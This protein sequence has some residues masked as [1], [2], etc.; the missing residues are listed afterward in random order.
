MLPHASI[1]LRATMERKQ[2][3]CGRR[4]LASFLPVSRSKPASGGSVE[5]IPTIG[6]PTRFRSGGCS[7][8]EP[9]CLMERGWTALIA[10]PRRHSGGALNEAS[11]LEEAGRQGRLPVALDPDRK[12]YCAAAGGSFEF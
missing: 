3:S 12:R 6:M 7:G 10:L 4:R 2:R 8:H 11:T 1:I 5:I 9:G